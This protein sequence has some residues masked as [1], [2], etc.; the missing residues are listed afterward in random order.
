MLEIKVLA[1][2]KDQILE[3]A[4]DADSGT[5]VHKRKSMRDPSLKSTLGGI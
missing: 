5:G 4:W 1:V 2:K 3:Y